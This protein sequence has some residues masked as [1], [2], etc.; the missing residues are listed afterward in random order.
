MKVFPKVSSQKFALV[1]PVCKGQSKAEIGNYRTI[2]ILSILSKVLEKL[3]LNRQCPV[4]NEIY[5]YGVPQGSILGPNLFILDIKD[6]KNLSL[7]LI[8]FWRQY[9]HTSD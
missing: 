9:K 7:V 6:I 2:S 8:F 4:R 1:I 3:M 5:S